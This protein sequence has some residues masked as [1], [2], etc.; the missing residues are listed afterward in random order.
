M[1]D[2]STGFFLSI[3]TSYLEITWLWIIYIGADGFTLLFD[4][5]YPFWSVETWSLSTLRA[6]FYDFPDLLDLL[7]SFFP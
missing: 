6:Y 7:A 4:E 3:S 1:I 2:V 5:F